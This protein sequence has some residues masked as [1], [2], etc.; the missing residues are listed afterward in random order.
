LRK[1]AAQNP[2]RFGERLTEVLSELAS[3]LHDL[4]RL[5]EELQVRGEVV[6]TLR[7][8]ATTD[9]GISPR[10]AVAL[11]DF[12]RRLAESGREDEA[13]GVMSEAAGIYGKLAA[14]ERSAFR[15]RLADWLDRLWIQARRHTQIPRLRTDINRVTDVYRDL[16]LTEPKPDSP[17]HAQALVHLA[18]ALRRVGRNDEA[19]T[20]FDSA[21]KAYRDLLRAAV[22]GSTEGDARDIEAYAQALVQVAH[23]SDQ[24]KRSGKAADTLPWKLDHIFAELDLYHLGPTTPSASADPGELRA[25][26]LSALSDLSVRLWKLGERDAALDTAQAGRRLAI[27]GYPAPARPMSWEPVTDHDPAP[28]LPQPSTSTWAAAGRLFD[29]D[30]MSLDSDANQRQRLADEFDTRAFRLLASEQAHESC[31][32]SADAVRCAEQAVEI[33]RLL[34]D[35]RPSAYLDDL[36]KAL[37]LLAKYLRKVDSRE[38][39]AEDAAREAHEIRCL[40]GLSP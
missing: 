7:K 39:E 12:A 1:L 35:A 28:R 37:D 19:A 5:A 27:R 22:G 30:V 17:A 13:P 24:L 16:V 40:L 23:A 21:S 3:T 20:F 34:A 36:A 18:T 8:M 33:Y 11:E 26:S 31:M 2:A 32:A 38:P 14:S 29:M 15:S 10:L 9:P 6:A 25:L 4:G